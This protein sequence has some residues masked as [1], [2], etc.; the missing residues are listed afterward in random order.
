[1]AK[2][3]IEIE[4]I[5]RIFKQRF[6]ENSRSWGNENPDKEQVAKNQTEVLVEIPNT[7]TLDS[8][9]QNPEG[10]EFNKNNNTFLLSSLNA[11]PIIKVNLDGTFKPFTSGE[12]Y[13]V[14]TAGLQI[15]YKN[16]RLLVAGFNGMEL[17]DQ[18]PKTKGM[19]ALRIYNLETGVLEKDINLSSL[20]PDAPAYF[21]NDVA[22]DDQGNSYISDWYA[23]VVYKVDMG[24]NA[25][26]FWKNEIAS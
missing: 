21:A 2:I 7:I 22:V 8:I 26:V 11:T 13:P 25:S 23:G 18:D 6:S 20:V 15:D 14:S 24:G 1:M 19:S 17:Y 9:A 16:N 4:K 5:K 3:P 10:I 12:A